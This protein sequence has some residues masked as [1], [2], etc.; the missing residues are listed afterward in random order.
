MGLK[1]DL[2]LGGY[3]EMGENHLDFQ[4]ESDFKS[5]PLSFFLTQEIET[6]FLNL[7]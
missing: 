1:F 7:H 5:C 6:K 3:H 2:M 4:A